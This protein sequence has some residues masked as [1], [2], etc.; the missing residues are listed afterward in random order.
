MKYQRSCSLRAPAAGPFLCKGGGDGFLIDVKI[1]LC[2]L[3]ASAIIVFK[4]TGRQGPGLVRLD[5]RLGALGRKEMS[6]SD[7]IRRT[8]TR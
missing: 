8:N 2:T 4:V 7:K 5:L 1:E 6:H 3:L